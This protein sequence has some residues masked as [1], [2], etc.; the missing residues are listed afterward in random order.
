MKFQHNV[1]TNLQTRSSLLSLIDYF[2]FILFQLQL[3]VYLFSTIKLIPFSGRKI[4]SVIS[5]IS[6]RL[7]TDL[8]LKLRIIDE[9]TDFSSNIANFWPMPIRKIVVDENNNCIIMDN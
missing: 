5:V 2:S 4:I 6:S 3:N 1:N 9:I 8:I 7:S